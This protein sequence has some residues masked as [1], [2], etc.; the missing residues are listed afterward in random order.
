MRTALKGA[1]VEMNKK[2]LPQLV[3][4]ASEITPPKERLEAVA[5]L[6]QMP[7]QRPVAHLLCDCVGHM[8]HPAWR[9]AAAQALGYHKAGKEFEEVQAQLVEYAQKERDPIVAR[10]IVFALQGSKGAKAL[11][12][13]SRE[14]VVL[15]VLF[16]MSF[17]QKDLER[18]LEIYFQRSE[19]RILKVILKQVQA[20]GCCA[21]VVVRF[22]MSADGLEDLCSVSGRIFQLFGVLDQSDLFRALIG[23]TEEIQRTYRDIWTGIRRRERQQELLGIFEDRVREDGASKSFIRAVVEIIG[24]AD[25]AIF[26]RYRRA[27]RSLMG[28]MGLEEA[29]FLIQEAETAGRDMEKAGIGRLAELLVALVRSV[30]AVAPQAQS[31]LGQWKVI[32]PGAQVQAFQAR[33][34]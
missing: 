15:E 28:A 13:H 26:D 2:D 21:S 23:R 29:L 24:A 30:P 1:G 34:R 7:M 33:A 8:D 17:F 3:R 14:E 31:V 4:Q 32:S 12:C 19:T 22:L 5:R 20:G 18:I 10:A 25:E 6:K 27:L 9:T 11:L 16:G